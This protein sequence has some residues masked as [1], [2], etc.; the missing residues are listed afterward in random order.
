MSAHMLLDGLEIRFDQL[1]G[2]RLIEHYY[3]GNA[4][5]GTFYAGF[6]WSLD[7][8]VRRAEQVERAFHSERRNALRSA[9]TAT[10]PAA[11]HK[12]EQIAAGN[13]F[14]ITTG[15]QAGL[16]GGPLYTA[17]KILTAVKLAQRLEEAL[18]VPVAPLF[19]I[20][21]DDHDWAEINHAVVVDAQ[22][23]IVRI[24]LKGSAEPPVSMARR[25]LGDSVGAALARLESA[26]PKNDFANAQ[27]ARL[28]T[29]YQP[30]ASVASAFGGWIA[31][32]FQAF[33][34]LITSSNDPAL[35]AHA[36]PV[37]R[38]ELERADVHARL[39][40]T[41]TDRLLAAGYHE[42]VAIS[43]DAANVMFEDEHGRERLVR[44]AGGWLVRRTRRTFSHQDVLR[45]LE[46]EPDRFSAN[47]LLRPVIESYSFPT[48]AYVGGPAEISYFGQIGCLFSAH[49][50]AMPLV[51][52]RASAD[53]VES[54]IR[55]VLDKFQLEPSDLRRP[56]HEIASQIARDEL[57]DAVRA[58]LHQ[59]REDVTNGY[60]GLVAAAQGIDVTLRGPLESARNAS[61]KHVEDAERK[62]L[63]HLKKQ[64]E[65]GLDQLRK[66]SI[67]LYPDGERQERVLG[68][69]GY[70]G[71]YGDEL[72]AAIAEALDVQLDIAVTGWDG[73]RCA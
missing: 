34:L 4:E 16:F 13:G 54:K 46:A 68:T 21:A 29:V 38:R 62:I 48:L 19:W 20:P 12:L 42:Q 35:K 56:F 57:P 8:F 64:N 32:T 24:E 69:I 9:V 33:D 14:V 31:E 26:L 52:P 45:M 58:A 22:N 27:L 55:K 5:L 60:A 72:L 11:A 63:N 7:A 1:G 6:P 28:S 25:R 47:V 65:I 40:R 39:L 10:T 53:L 71:R 23:Q 15:Q 51:L 70:L 30:A 59:L 2:S 73:V 66:A 41:Q 67:H 18:A 50:V 37:F 17:Y 61:H 43:A 49:E 3:A 44:E 36:L